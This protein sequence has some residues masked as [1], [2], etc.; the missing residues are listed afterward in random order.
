MYKYVKRV[1]DIIISV[2]GL[3]FFSGL[4][5]IIAI[6]IKLESKGP[7]IFKQ[8]R[9]GLNGRTFNI[10]KFRSMYINAENQGSG[11]YSF[12]DDPRVTKVGKIIRRTSLDELP[13]FFNII[14]GNM[15]LIGPRP[16]L[17]YH[18]WTLDNYPNEA[19]RRFNVQPGITGLAQVN[20]RKG[21][22]WEDRFVYDLTYVENISFLLDLKIFLI[23]VK[24]V[25]FM[26][27][28]V[29]IIK[30]VEK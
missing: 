23:T 26:E 29:N 22:P 30:T 14:I 6:A 5:L 4:M 13:Q 8:K 25:L 7:V 1:I 20:G 9:L 3:C 2:V 11:Q 17:T 27:D 15:S 19:K 16:T 18:P 21:L 28:N 10:Y 24:K 12:A